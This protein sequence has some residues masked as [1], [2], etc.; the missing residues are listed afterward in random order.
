MKTI[1]EIIANYAEYKTPIED[2]FVR[3]FTTFLIQDQGAKIW[4]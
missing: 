1:D 3:R 2:R 4:I